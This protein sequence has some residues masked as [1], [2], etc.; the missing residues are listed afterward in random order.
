M[1]WTKCLVT[2]GILNRIYYNRARKLRVS[3][4]KGGHP[5]IAGIH[6][7]AGLLLGVQNQLKSALNNYLLTISEVEITS[8]RCWFF[9]WCVPQGVSRLIVC[10]KIRYDL[11]NVAHLNFMHFPLLTHFKPMIHLC[12]PWKRQK[13]W[14]FLI[15]SGRKEMDYW[16][17]IG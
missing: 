1:Q 2:N 16:H 8:C 13:T 14:N 15:F 4:R 11:L 12:T 5:Y 6:D 9:T 10:C 3:V 7:T 17:E